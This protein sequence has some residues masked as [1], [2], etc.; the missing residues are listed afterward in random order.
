MVFKLLYDCVLVCCVESD[1][2]I[3]GGLIIFDSVKEKLVEGEVIVCGE[4][5]CKDLGE[6]IVMVVKEGDCILFGKWFGIE[7]IVDG[8]ELLI[9]KESD[10][11]GII[12]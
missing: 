5:V 9:M 6:L 12:V 3:K 2:K 11:L 1:E 7:V 4:G 10:I 8:E